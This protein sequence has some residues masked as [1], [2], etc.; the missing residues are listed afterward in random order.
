MEGLDFRRNLSSAWD[1][2]G[3]YATDIFTEEAERIIHEH[4]SSTPLLLYLSHLACHAGN[5]GKLVEAPQHV[6][7][8]FHYITE[9]N[10]RSYAGKCPPLWCVFD[11]G[12]VICAHLHRSCVLAV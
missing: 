3:R 8:M 12:H 7:N 5:A 10:R 6:I 1:L 9:P 2:T 4:N 11:S